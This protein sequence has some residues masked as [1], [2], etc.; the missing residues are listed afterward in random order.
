MTILK[1][2]KTSLLVVVFHRNLEDC[3]AFSLS[4]NVLTS[5]ILTS[6]LKANGDVFKGRVINVVRLHFISC[7]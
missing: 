4:G 5:K 3:I 6:V 1:V 7:V 2:N